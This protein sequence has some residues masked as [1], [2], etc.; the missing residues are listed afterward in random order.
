LK[1]TIHLSK[2][3]KRKEKKRSV[4]M[5]LLLLRPWESCNQFI[6]VVWYY[7]KVKSISIHISISSSL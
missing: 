6:G 2:K 5:V 7:S 1:G 4:G 3:K